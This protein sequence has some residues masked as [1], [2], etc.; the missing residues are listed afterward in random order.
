MR[1]KFFYFCLFP[2]NGF[3]RISPK[4][5]IESLLDE[6]DLVTLGGI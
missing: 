1:P 6:H 5:S 3:S 4:I 2:S